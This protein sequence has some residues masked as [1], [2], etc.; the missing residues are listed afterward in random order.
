MNT[1][2]ANAQRL[3]GSRLQPNRRAASLQSGSPQG[4]GAKRFAEDEDDENEDDWR[5]LCLTRASRLPPEFS[6][7]L[8]EEPS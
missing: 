3:E 6:A 5:Q 8:L 1:V 7:N 2:P 4:A